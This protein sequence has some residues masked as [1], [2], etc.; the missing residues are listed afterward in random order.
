M[1]KHKHYQAIRAFADGWPIE[2]KE[3][4]GDTW[5]VSPI[6]HFSTNTEYR[7]VATVDGWLPWSPYPNATAPV[8]GL[9]DICLADGTVAVHPHSRWEWDDQQTIPITH[10]RVHKPMTQRE[11]IEH[12]LARFTVDIATIDKIMAIVKQG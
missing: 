7:I 5:H 3:I 11:R 1:E 4:N 12:V 9:V 8:D 6:P 10:Y 2:V